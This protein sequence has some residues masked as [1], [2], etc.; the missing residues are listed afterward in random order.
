MGVRTPSAEHAAFLLRLLLGSLFIA[1]LYW[2]FAVLP[3]G[4][5]T[6]WSNLANN[7]Y[8]SFVAAYVLSAEFAGA[9]LLIPGIFARYVALYCVPMMI[10]AA[11]FWLARKG[12]Y[13]PDSRRG[14]SAGVACASRDPERGGGRRLCGL[15]LA[16]LARPCDEARFATKPVPGSAVHPLPTHRE[17]ERIRSKRK[18]THGCRSGSEADRRPARAGPPL[19]DGPD[20]GGLQ[21]RPRRNGRS[22]LGIGMVARAPH[23]GTGCAF[24]PRGS[25]LLRPGRNPEPAPRR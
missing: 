23:P 2:K 21:G 8:P 11:Q 18:C 17:D 15:A 5:A 25:C 1:H 9:L 16:G 7:G 3:G 6:W 22:L 10:G 12:F 13:F 20:S 4:V 14:A 24:A 19:P